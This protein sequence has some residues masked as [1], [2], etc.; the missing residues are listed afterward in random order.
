MSCTEPYEPVHQW[1]SHTVKRLRMQLPGGQQP[2]PSSE[3]TAVHLQ[4]HDHCL[5]QWCLSSPPTGSLGHPRDRMAEL[6]MH[7]NQ[8]VQSQLCLWA[9]GFVG[10]SRWRQSGETKHE[11]TTCGRSLLLL[12]QMR[13]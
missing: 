10:V 4:Q 3:G 13:I 1:G 6:K 7:R 5:R 12:H 9:V 8:Q 2:H 11:V